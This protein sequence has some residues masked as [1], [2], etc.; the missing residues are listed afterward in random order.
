MKTIHKKH[1]YVQKENVPY[2]Y[3]A[4]LY[5]T[6]CRIL[7]ISSI[8]TAIFRYLTIFM[9][10]WK[11]LM[12]IFFVSYIQFLLHHVC[13]NSIMPIKLSNSFY[14]QKHIPETHIYFFLSVRILYSLTIFRPYCFLGIFMILPAPSSIPVAQILFAILVIIQ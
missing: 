2:I 11:I 5:F 6:I 1:T 9:K 4:Y 7:K 14:F 13:S 3:N 12:C 8:E 10:I